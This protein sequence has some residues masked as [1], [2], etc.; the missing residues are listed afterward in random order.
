MD[1]QVGR[2]REELIRALADADGL[3]VRSETRVDRALLS[4]GPKLAVVARAGA[5]VDAI[6]VEAATDAGVIVLNTPGA[7]TLSATEQT[8]ALM[9]ALARKVPQAVQMVREGRWERKDLV[10]TEL[11][12]K[13]L[14][15]VGLGRIGGAVASRAKAFGMNLIG[16][17]PF[18]SSARA[19]AFDIKLV[20]LETLL[21]EADIVTLHVPLTNG[22]RGLI[23]GTKLR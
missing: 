8:F 5:G 20:D 10:G 3:I 21:R 9:L 14:G 4:E 23:D 22:T 15:I 18:V 11:A 1:S 7:N 12:G 19:E 16:S 13:T 2:S 6:D 17:D